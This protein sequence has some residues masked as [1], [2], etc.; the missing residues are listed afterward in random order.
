MLKKKTSDYIY[1]YSDKKEGKKD[2]FLYCKE[3]RKIKLFR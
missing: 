3:I 2:A 1:F